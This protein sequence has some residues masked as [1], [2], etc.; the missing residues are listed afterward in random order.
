MSSF[1]VFLVKVFA[2]FFAA[3]L[4]MLGAGN[5]YPKGYVDLGTSA[6]A[7]AFDGSIAN[8]FR[9]TLSGNATITFTNLKPGEIYALQVVQNGVGGFTPVFAGGNLP[10]SQRPFTPLQAANA[11]T[12]LIFMNLFEAGG[13]FA[14]TTISVSATPQGGPLLVTSLESPEGSNLAIQPGYA[15]AAHTYRGLIT[16]N[17]GKLNPATSN[18]LST[19]WTHPE[20]GTLMDGWQISGTPGS[21]DSNLSLVRSFSNAVVIQRLQ[22]SAG[23]MQWESLGGGDFYFDLTGA[24]SSWNVRTG[25]TGHIVVTTA[26]EVTIAA[27]AD[28][29][30]F[31]GGAPVAKQ[32]LANAT[33]DAGA[34]ASLIDVGAVFS[35]ANINA[36]FAAIWKKLNN[37]NL[38]A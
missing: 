25:A 7:F 37:Y 19:V 32:V 31:F 35:Q 2:W 30:A 4:A 15:T 12:T 18:G 33:G 11:A 34:A 21:P 23:Y 17:T 13:N 16:V 20:V 6:T 5:S 14:F 1:L 8:C 36:N 27:A 28:T 29:L 24:G 22:A 9:C 10:T 38:W 3:P 26:G